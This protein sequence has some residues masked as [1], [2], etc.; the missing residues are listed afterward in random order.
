M[1]FKLN[2]LFELVI[3]GGLEVVQLAKKIWWY[4]TQKAGQEGICM[5]SKQSF[6]FVR[7][8]I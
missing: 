2:L 4:T 7:R 3:D 6:H 8:D 5:G 1:I